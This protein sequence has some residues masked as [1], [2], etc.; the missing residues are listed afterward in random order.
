MAPAPVVVGI[1]HDLRFRID[2]R[3]VTGDEA[4]DAACEDL[5]PD[6]RLL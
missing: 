6:H 3:E 1:A 5:E 4:A 2:G